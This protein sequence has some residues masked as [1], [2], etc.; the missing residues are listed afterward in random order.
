MTDDSNRGQIV[1]QGARTHC[2]KNI[3][4]SIPRN[5][6]VVVTGKSGSGKSTLAHDTLFA[7]GQRQYLESV[8]T[9]SRKFVDQLPLADV[10]S[11]SGLPPTICLD[12]RSGSPSPRSTVG[13]MTEIYD[14]L[15]VLLAQVG[16]V[17]CYQCGDAISQ[18]TPVEIRS[19]LAALP[20]GTRMMIL[21]PVVRNASGDITETLTRLRRERLVRVRVDGA[22]HDIESVPPVDDE[23]PHS[24]D[25]VTDRIIIRDDPGTRLEKAIELAATLSGGGVLASYVTPEMETATPGIKNN[26]ANWHEQ[27]F[28]T[29]HACAK[30]D[31]EYAEIQPRSFSFNSPYGSCTHCS[32]T[33]R[34]FRFDPSNVIDRTLSIADGAVAPWRDTSAAFS[35]A[36]LAEMASVLAVTHLSAD[37][38]L[39]QQPTSDVEA[40]INC[41]DGDTPGILLLLER[42]LA[43]TED[44]DRFELLSS[45]EQNLPCVAC[46][47]SR[48]NETANAVYF[49][50]ANI[51]AIV[52]MPIARSIPFFESSPASLDSR[53]Q[54][55]AAPILDAILTRLRYLENAGVD[56]LTLSRSAET[57][58]GGELQ[59]V[60]LGA[61]IGSGLTGACYVLDEPSIGLHPRDS[62]RLIHSL[63]ELQRRGNSVIVVEHDEAMIRQADHVI[64]MGPGAGEAGG[65]VVAEGTPGEIADAPQSLTGD[66]L[67]GQQEIG[68]PNLRRSIDADRQIRIVGASGYNLKSVTVEIPLGVLVCVTGVSGS[69]KTTLIDRT[70]APE[71][72]HH[73]GLMSS[74]PQPLE[75]IEGLKQVQRLVTID[76]RPVGR[77][78]KSC[79]ATYS[80]VFDQF[81]KIFAATKVARQRGYG[82]GRFS[83]NSPAGRCSRCKGHGSQRVSMDL[84]PDQF[85]TCP[86]CRGQ[87]FNPPTLQAM[88]GELSISDVLAMSI[89]QARERFDGF[90]RIAATLTAIQE[91]GLGYLRLGQPA[92][93]LSGGEAQRLRLARELAAPTREH[94]VY[95]LDEPTSGLHLD[96]VRQLLGVLQ[97]LVNEGHSMIVVEHHLD[98]IKSADWVIDMGPDGGEGGGEVVAV[99]T[100]EDIAGHADSLTGKFLK[101]LLD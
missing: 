68:V 70:F 60:R 12:Q 24:I 40:A 81:R 100:P 77:S 96:D 28:S 29:R 83:F 98:V 55:I 78:S 76:Q 26:P 58:S 91:V 57:L 7:E 23:Q 97:R 33:G 15:R 90:S 56:Y 101:P 22:I 73:L 85:V 92:P 66:Y 72:K 75:R 35:K 50:D 1:I 65:N 5:Q 61:S 69:G 64:D 3:S 31:I 80:G 36:R 62:D 11:I 53:Q 38:P 2:L 19:T 88:F 45:L 93:T 52:A 20:I 87:R 86:A 30:C 39:D 42:E 25:A 8:G 6:F 99:G 18:Q 79:P 59:R 13:T 27:S 71:A 32:G 21:A 89:D 43:I 67:N 49:N 10:D 47:G 54:Q 34:Q 14:Y 16:V 37:K 46:K 41:R 4:L 48:V 94:T 44:D 17:R 82:I 51:G 84:M 9:F 74:Y 95:L 63:R